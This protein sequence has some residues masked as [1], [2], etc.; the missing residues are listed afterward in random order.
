MPCVLS[1]PM[2]E[3]KRKHVYACIADGQ[4]RMMLLL[5]FYYRLQLE[6]VKEGIGLVFGCQRDHRLGSKA[7]L[8]HLR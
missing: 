2:T 1:I 6:K 5:L 4:W 7:C 3:G 8:S